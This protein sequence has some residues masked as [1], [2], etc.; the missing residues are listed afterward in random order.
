[1]SDFLG[2]VGGF[3]GGSLGGKNSSAN[4]SPE[5]LALAE[6]DMGERT[7]R[8]DTSFAGSGL[9]ASTMRTFANAGAGIGGAEQAAGFSDA[10]LAALA[11]S[12]SLQNLLNQQAYSQGV[13][14]GNQQSGDGSG[15]GDTTLG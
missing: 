13:N 3:L 1:M 2:Q 12:S 10:M 14:L 11:P 9:G 7:L 15:S 4:L 8:N 5:Q 6:Y